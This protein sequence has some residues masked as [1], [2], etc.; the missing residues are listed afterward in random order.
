MESDD[1]AIILIRIAIVTGPCAITAVM[2]LAVDTKGMQ[3]QFLLFVSIIIVLLLTLIV[4][5]TAPK[6]FKN[7]SS[8]EL[9]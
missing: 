5:L 3:Q 1:I 2:T 6:I 4:F 8:Q 7:W 9:D